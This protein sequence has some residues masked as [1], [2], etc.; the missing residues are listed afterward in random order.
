MEVNLEYIQFKSLLFDASNKALANY[1]VVV[2]F[3]NVNW[4]SWV[5]LTEILT[6]KEGKLFCKLELPDR[7]SLSN[8]TIRIVRETLK[9]GSVPAFRVIKYTEEKSIP[10][11]IATYYNMTLEA[12]ILTID[13]GKNGLLKDDKISNEKTH[14]IIASSLPVLEWENTIGKLQQENEKLV[15]QQQDFTN[16]ITALQTEKEQLHKTV[17][18]LKNQLETLATENE[19]AQNYQEKYLQLESVFNQIKAEKEKLLTENQ[20]FLNT[21][22]QLQGE[23]KIQSISIR[24]KEEELLTKQQLIVSQTKNIADLQQEL[25][26]VNQFNL[27]EEPNKLTASQVY[28]SIV[29]DVIKADEELVNAKYKLA[30]ISLNLKTTV[31]KGPSGTVLGLLGLETATDVNSAAISTINIDVVPNATVAKSVDQK[32][33]NILGLTETAVRKVLL[34]YGLKLDAIYHPTDDPTLIEGQSFK[35]SPNPE[36]TIVEGQ[37]VIVI[38][39][40]PLN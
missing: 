27:N 11:I 18:S 1:N 35:Q 20:S 16:E 28:S 22:N 33:P 4:K 17:A 3:Y 12:D 31:E 8:Q 15:N 21:I 6:V 14:L 19:M 39:S 5:T 32:M 24:T 7:I 34:E 36:S 10:Q 37:E 38:F 9:A 25:E 26:E 2:Q 13:F 23:L 40:K 29:K 30:N